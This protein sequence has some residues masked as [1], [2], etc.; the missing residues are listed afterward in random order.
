MAIKILHTADIH[1]GAAF[2]IAVNRP[3]IQRKRIKETFSRI[4]ELCNNGD[5]DLLLIAG[6]LFDSSSPGEVEWVKSRFSAL[7]CPVC[8]IPGNHDFYHDESV[9]AAADFG[10]HVEIFT[11]REGGK[12][13][14]SEL[15]L[16]VCGRPDVSER[17]YESPLN[18][19]KA[20]KDTEYNIALIHGSFDDGRAAKDDHLFTEEQIKASGFNYIAAGHWHS[21]REITPSPAC[22]YSGSP[23]ILSYGDSAAGNVL[24][25]TIDENGVKVKPLKLSQTRLLKE[26]I[27]LEL[28]EWKEAANDHIISHLK[29]KANADALLEVVLTGMVGAESALDAK[30]IE[31]ELS[32][33]FLGAKVKDSRIFKIEKINLAEYPDSMVIGRFLRKVIGEMEKADSEEYRRDLQ[34]V[35]QMGLM[36]LEGRGEIG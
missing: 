10:D 4:I 31:D 14:Y 26:E 2:G 13:V 3:D 9:Y 29:G 16:T 1:L 30:L 24:E 32:E 19:L 33:S 27:N 25:V 11:E 7:S 15:D 12:K 17:S 35:L 8:L 20:S 6:D 23:E 28:P 21:M 36:I 18:R 5:Y 22:W 34:E